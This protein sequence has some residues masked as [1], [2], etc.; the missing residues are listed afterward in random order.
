MQEQLYKAGKAH[1][2]QSQTAFTAY[3]SERSTAASKIWP[4]CMQKTLKAA[5]QNKKVLMLML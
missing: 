2:K 3:R 4:D 1:S 5:R